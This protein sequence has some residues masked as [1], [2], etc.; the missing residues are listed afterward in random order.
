MK[1]F[2]RRDFIKTSTMAA[3]GLVMSSSLLSAQNKGGDKINVALIGMGAEG[4]VLLNSLIKLPNL[5]FVAICD[6]WE[7][8]CNYAAMR[9]FRERKQA[10]ARY[11]IPLSEK[12]RFAPLVKAKRVGEIKGE[13]FEDVIKNHAKELDAV[14][15]ATPDFWHSP[16]TVAFLEAGVNVY[17]EKMMSDTLEG[18][19]AM[20]RAA[21]KTGKLLQIGHQRTSN[22]RY[23]YAREVLL[24][25]H[26]IC[27]NIMAANGQW[28]RAVT[29]DLTWAKN[30]EIPVEKL[31]KY[32][33][34]DMNQFRNWRWHKGLGGGAISDL[35]AHQID[36]FGWMFGAHPTRVMASGNRD[37]YKKADGT[38]AHDWDDNVM[39]IFEFD[40][41][42]QGK[43]AQA[44]YQVL[45]T[46]SS[47]G[48]YFES[49]MG[50]QGTLKMSE[51][52][53]LTK[54]FRE[55]NAPDWKPLIDKG[56]IGAGE[57][58]APAAKIADA[59]ETKA[60]V[61]YSFPTNVAG[62]EPD[63]AKKPIHMY[64]IENFFNA[65]LGKEKLNCD[66][67]HAYE[68]EAAV[69]KAREAIVKGPLTFSES[70]FVV[71]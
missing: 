65:L 1:D 59:R 71:D 18:A 2:T 10:P 61:G 48:G 36:I 56:I 8:R 39:C 67:V 42:F 62:Y 6:I 15:I 35:G 51:N 28:N 55:N 7:P 22:P 32:G 47:G 54:L 64:H 57:A 23:K 12:D 63:V 46:T 9:I 49:F 66:A 40:K 60:L 31:N 41:T 20:V 21:K 24:R 37:Y 17:C 11:T 3:G 4:E 70:D 52:P 43:K 30:Q 68:A 58:S 16:M 25:K 38:P 14:I 34:K 45:T 29:K 33:F 27:G 5:N 50:D 44:F 19:K 26:N 13:N 69:F 53:A